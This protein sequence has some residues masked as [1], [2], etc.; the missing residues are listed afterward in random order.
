MSY[1][2]YMSIS[3]AY[4]SIYEDTTQQDFLELVDQLVE[5]GY[6]LSE[7]TYDELYEGYLSEG[8]LG[9]I[10]KGA[11]PILKNLAGS[12]YRTTRKG[13]SKSWHGTTVQTPKGPK[14][15]PGSKQELGRQSAVV[16]NIAAKILP[17]AAIAGAADLISGG[18]VGDTISGL[19]SGSKNPPTASPS[20]PPQ[21]PSQSPSQRTLRIVGGKVVGYNESYDSFDMIK[22]HLISEGYADTEESAL[23]I[24][25][26]MSEEWMQCI[27]EAEVIAMKN[28]VP[29]SV[30]VRPALSIP[31]TN[32]GI[33]PNVPI[34]GTFTTTTPAQRAQIAAGNSTI[35]RGTYRQ[36]RVGAGPTSQERSRYNAEL[37]KQGK[38]T[39]RRMPK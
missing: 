36:S 21:A 19:F 31:G 23:T 2:N 13:V 33:G 3:E 7:Y 10:L 39:S 26:N 11:V 17:Y 28:G 29:G 25:A 1:S 24:M 8:G 5:E 27:I 34:P 32:I 14:F 12:A 15:V 4:S 35:D 18:K 9:S 22:D 16:G 38:H 20:S 37:A 6:D 30:Q